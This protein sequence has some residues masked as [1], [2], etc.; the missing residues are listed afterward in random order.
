[1]IK[2]NL[3]E[4][5]Q[6]LKNGT[7]TLL[8]IVESYIDQ[9]YKTSDLNIYVNVF[10]YEAK[11]AAKLL[12]RKIKKHPE[13]LGRLFGAVISIKDVICYKDHP[14]SAGSKIL[15]G[16]ESLFSATAVERLIAEDAII[17]GSTNCDEF[18][19]GSSNEN[20]YYGPVKNADNPEYIPGG[21]SG[22]AAVSVQAGTCLIALGSDTGGSVRQPA[23]FCGVVGMKPTYGR[24]SRHGLI[25]YASSFDQIG[26]V[27]RNVEDLALVLEVISG[28]DEYDSTV[29]QLPVP[30]FSEKINLKK[31][32]NIGV[33][34]S[35]FDHSKMNQEIRDFSKKSID[36]IEQ[37]GH[38]ISSVD[39]S[40]I[41]YLVPA[42]YVMT[43]AEASSNLS[44]YDGVKFGYR[45]SNNSDLDS[46]YTAT[47]SEGFGIEVKRRIMLGTFVLSSG[48][49]DAYFEKAQKIRTLIKQ[50]I[51]QLFESV[52]V[53]A[54]PISMDFPWKIGDTNQDP[55]TIYLSDVFT[56]IANIC[57]IPAISLPIGKAE[58]NLSSGIQLLSKKF[59]EQDLFDISS[60]FQ[61]MA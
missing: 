4:V 23:A 32:L 55:V 13:K 19:M 12:D 51:D 36:K 9:I 44:R 60:Q 10:D 25:A 52:D 14:V 56:V 45:S 46:L 27:G 50:E 20:S 7:I 16:F 47:R 30:A 54:I 53:L 34:D 18:A 61:S 6:D 11:Q 48:Y 39:F 35:F 26:I 28:K 31:K 15:E 1:M 24:I 38:K 22:G 17:I 40:M 57:G 58:N 43:T 5:Q 42:Y 3:K 21:S 37:L 59:H 2:N 49:Y 29:S 8:D 41:D 33:I